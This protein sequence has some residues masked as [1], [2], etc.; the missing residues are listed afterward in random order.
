MA[1]DM[2][3]ILVTEPDGPVDDML[4]TVGRALQGGLNGIIVRRPSA[5]TTEIFEITRRLRPATRK[6]N[7]RLLVHDRADI[8]VA[9]DA[10]GVHLGNGSLP[11][12]AARRVVGPGRLVGLSV[13]NLDET[14]Q[15]VAAGVDYML[16]GHVFAS[17]S[18][19]DEE[20]LG[21]PHFK[22]A[23]LRS[24]VPVYAIGGVSTD[25]VRLIAQAG[26]PGAAA[27]GAF[28]RVEDPAETARA[29][30]AAF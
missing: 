23:V 10:D 11:P 24:R 17:T 7:C 29:F 27:I 30:R 25:N 4:G 28:A 3:A 9:A 22:E 26:G 19:P 8:A 16:L 2:T 21:L 6:F 13:H 15:A 18:H 20:P 1:P 14:G 5:G 12:A